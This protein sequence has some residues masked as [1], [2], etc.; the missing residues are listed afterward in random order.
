[1]WS[2]LYNRLAGDD[3]NITNNGIKYCRALIDLVDHWRGKHTS[4]K[5]I[6]PRGAIVV[7]SSIKNE[8]GISTIQCRDEFNKAVE[9]CGIPCAMEAGSTVLLSPDF[10]KDFL[11][12]PK[13]KPLF[14]GAEWSNTIIFNKATSN[15]KE[16]KC[17]KIK[18]QVFISYAHEDHEMRDKLITHL[19]ALKYKNICYWFDGNIEAGNR[20]NDEIKE[21][22]NKSQV[23]ILM[24][25]K[26]F[27]N[28]E[29]I[30]NKEIPG[31]IEQNSLIIPI[32]L[33]NCLWNSMECIVERL[34]IPKN[35]IPLSKIDKNKH[36]EIFT[37]IANRILTYFT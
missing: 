21:A 3:K 31:I 12:G 13:L 29:Y 35:A 36:D 19:G 37:K 32:L 25:S 30:R 15:N 10:Q 16:K 8:L 1:M 5:G 11:W 6:I 9:V 20:W 18:K 7:Q 27:L 28:S 17:L 34:I 22:I 2:K 4:D 33:D 24:V 23:F 26:Y 14:E